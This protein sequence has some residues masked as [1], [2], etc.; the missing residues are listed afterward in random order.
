[1]FGGCSLYA[2]GT[3]FAI[4]DSGGQLYLKAKGDFADRLIEAG[5]EMFRFEKDGEVRTMGYVTL[6]ADALDDPALACEWAREA[7]ALAED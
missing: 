3:I 1:M 4:L 7:L 6:P 5:G 2:G